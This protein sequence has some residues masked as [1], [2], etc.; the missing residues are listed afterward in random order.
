MS[1][2]EAEPSPL[3]RRRH[4]R[5]AAME[6]PLPSARAPP[7]PAPH[8]GQPHDWYAKETRT[9]NGDSALRRGRHRYARQSGTKAIPNALRNRR[10]EE[11]DEE[12]DAGRELLPQQRPERAAKASKETRAQAEVMNATAVRSA[13]GR[14]T[15]NEYA[16]AIA[17]PRTP[18]ALQLR[19]KLPPATPITATFPASQRP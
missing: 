14:P 11:E 8:L 15:A 7:R 3:S 1:C 5:S 16:K 13:S 17:T 18:N 10:H 19:R 6:P 12:E 9:T 2:G 4:G